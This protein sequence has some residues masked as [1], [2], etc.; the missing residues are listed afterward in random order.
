MNFS[1]AKKTRKDVFLSLFWL[2]TRM[3]LSTEYASSSPLSIETRSISNIHNLFKYTGAEICFA[4][5]LLNSILLRQIIC[6]LLSIHPKHVSSHCDLLLSCCSSLSVGDFSPSGKEWLHFC[7]A[8]AFRVTDAAVE[9]CD[10]IAFVVDA[11]G[12]ALCVRVQD[13]LGYKCQL[14]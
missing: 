4:H 12:G 9:V 7:L 10:E 5:M 11:L 6:W 1:K 14:G 13:T 8:V 2:I 3:S